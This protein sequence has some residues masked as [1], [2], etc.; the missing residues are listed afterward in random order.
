M[1]VHNEDLLDD[2]G[3]MSLATSANLKPVWIGHTPWYSVQL[4]FTG[5][6]AGSFKLQGS[7]DVGHINSASDT[8]QSTGVTNW[9]D[10]NITSGAIAAAGTYMFNVPDASY[11]WFRVVW[12]ATG[13]G[14]TPVLS[15][16]R[17]YIKG[18]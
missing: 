15:S 1:R 16:A 12:T 11:S 2:S 3:S 13:A 4:V 6:P 9:T 8:M 5:V 17:A 7:N 14:T 10:L 18:W